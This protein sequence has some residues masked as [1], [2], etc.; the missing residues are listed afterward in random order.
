MDSD[1]S[2]NLVARWRDGDQQAAAVLFQRYAD[3][4]IGLARSRLLKP[5]A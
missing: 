5:A 2:G 4:L 1:Q 3:R